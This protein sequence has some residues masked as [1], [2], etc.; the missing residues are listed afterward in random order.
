MVNVS[1]SARN[2]RRLNAAR[3]DSPTAA[4]LTALDL[5]SGAGGATQGLAD[6]GFNILGAIENDEAAA[7]SYRLNHGTPLVIVEDIRRLNSAW[8]R[9]KL[10]LQDRRLDLLNACPPC[11]GW[12][13]LGNRSVADTRNDLVDDVGRIIRE[14]G[15]RSWILENV[16]GLA[17]DPHLDRLVQKAVRAGYGVQQYHLDAQGFGVPQ[18]RKR[19]IV[20]G[21]RGRPSESLPKDLM[22]MIPA[23]FDRGPR[24]AGEAIKQAERISETEDP[25]HRG[26]KHKEHVVERIA[27]VPVGGNRFDLPHEHRLECHRRMGSRQAAAAYGRIRANRPAPTMTTRCT[28]PACGS[29]IH[30]T[31]NRG[32]TLREAA[33]IQSFPSNYAFFGSYGQIEAQI[34]NAFPPRMAEGI[35]RAVQRLLIEGSN[36]AVQRRQ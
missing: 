12:S 6:A 29:F 8:L 16:T 28:T 9:Q 33:L 36:N 7:K 10:G 18:R 17:R 2:P 26:R 21:L 25:L 27:A 31:E 4:Q 32:I 15:P 14:L 23:S 19:L 35:G 34:G 30:P 1:P 3:E 22:G 11:Q 20:I 5:F 13:S 24:T